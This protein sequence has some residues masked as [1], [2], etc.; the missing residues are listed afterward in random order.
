M[1]DQQAPPPSPQGSSPVDFAAL[2][3]SWVGVLT[4]PVPF[5][6]SVKTQTGLGPPL[7]FAAV[8]GVVYGVIVAI[9]AVVGLGMTA[10]M[11][12][13]ALGAAA[14]LGMIVLGPVFAI[15][16]GSFIGGAI[17]HVISLIA[18]GKGSFEHSVRIASYSLAV[19]PIGALLAI[20]PLVRYLPS[21]YGLYLV[22][23]GVIALHQSDRKRTF[24]VAGVL[25]GIMVLFIVIGMLIGMAART[26]GNELRT[27]YGEG[28]EFQKEMQKSAEEMR[29]AAE[30]MRQE[31]EKEQ[32]K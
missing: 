16:G 23:L 27:R 7:V 13:G 6:E 10:G 31:M 1:T 2:V 19:I 25:A 24:V 29:K 12:G 26:A 28:S 30:K 14:G 15:I 22:A 8:M 17:V 5:W 32:R 20:I 21:F 4:K 11:T 9:Y 18:G 3:P